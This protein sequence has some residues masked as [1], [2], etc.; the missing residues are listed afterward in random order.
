MDED[1]IKAEYEAYR[2]RRNFLIDVEREASRHFDKYILTLAAGTFGLS[3]LFFERIAPHPKDG[4]EWLLI[5]A[6]VAFG[7]SIL[8]TLVSFLS[9]QESCSKDIEM[10]DG[11]YRGAIKGEKEIKN[12]FVTW[13]KWLN[14]VSMLLFIVGVIVLIIFSALNL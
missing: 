9:G 1:E 12:R 8:S 4:T 7:A 10:L 11:K 3:L 5:A 14:R 6:W 2:R 13:T